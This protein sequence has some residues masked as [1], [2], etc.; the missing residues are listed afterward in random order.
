MGNPRNRMCEPVHL[1]TCPVT[2]MSPT[3]M[4]TTASTTPCHPVCLCEKTCASLEQGPDSCASVQCIKECSCPDG[5]KMNPK[6]RF[7]CE[8]IHMPTCPVKTTTTTTLTTTASTTPC[9]P[10]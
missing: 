9:H 2:T 6:N 5:Y 1:P 8:P 7:I 10:V 3:T 4:T